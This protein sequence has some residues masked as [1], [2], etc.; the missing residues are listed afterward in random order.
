MIF[1]NK[2]KPIMRKVQ[3]KVKKIINKSIE[4]AR[5]YN[6]DEISIEHVTIA[7]INDYDNDAIKYLVELG[8]DV[9]ELHKKLEGEVLKEKESDKI[10]TSLI[11]MSL[12][13]MVMK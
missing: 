3:P 5:L 11:P 13:I 9:D 10:T 7:M 6:Q 12:I 4:E 2:D 1:I 8:I